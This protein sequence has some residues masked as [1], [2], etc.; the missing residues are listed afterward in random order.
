MQKYIST[1]IHLPEPLWRA[2]KVR[3]AEEGKSMKQLIVEGLSLLL[4]KSRA[5]ESPNDKGLLLRFAGK[6]EADVTDG[7]T[8][9]DEYLYD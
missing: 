1:N 9:H 3:A 2:V 4:R 5:T 6:V 8:H 7:S